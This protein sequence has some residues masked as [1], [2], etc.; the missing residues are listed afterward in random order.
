MPVFLVLSRLTEKGAETLL[1]R[2]ERVK[3]VNM[4][5]EGMGVKVKEQY[6]ML[7]DYDFVNIVEAPDEATLYK[8]LVNLNKRGT[9][10]TSTFKLIPVDEFL[11]ELRKP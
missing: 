11:E 9:I 10:K 3:E 7:G 1:T 5:L 6:I 4:E 8:A 2:P